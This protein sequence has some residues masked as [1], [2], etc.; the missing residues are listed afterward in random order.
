MTKYVALVKTIACT[1]NKFGFEK[2][3]NTNGR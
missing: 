2:K 3:I 1:T